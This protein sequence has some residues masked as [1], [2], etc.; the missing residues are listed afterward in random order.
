M[1]PR[2]GASSK[3]VRYSLLNPRKGDPVQQETRSQADAEWSPCHKKGN[4]G[5]AEFLSSRLGIQRSATPC[6]CTKRS[7]QPQ[8]SIYFA[9][10]YHGAIVFLAFLPPVHGHWG[11]RG[12][13]KEPVF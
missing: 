1:E 13:I 6:S 8:I 12:I 3:R 5:Q 7:A 10:K 4:K 9:L 11:A 2:E